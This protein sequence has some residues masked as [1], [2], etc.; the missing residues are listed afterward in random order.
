MIKA[1]SHITTRWWSRILL[2]FLLWFL[3]SNVEYSI[4]TEFFPWLSCIAASL[5]TEYLRLGRSVVGLGL[6]LKKETFWREIFWGAAV[7][8]VGLGAILL[9]AVVLGARFKSAAVPFGIDVFGL[10]FFKMLV[11]A[12]GEEFLF[13]GIMFQAVVE[14]FK[15]PLAVVLST[16]IFIYGHQGNPGATTISSINIALANLLFCAMY[17]STGSLWPS[18]SFH[19]SWNFTQAL[20]GLPV[21]GLNFGRSFLKMDIWR[22]PENMRWLVATN[23]FG[24]ESGF[25]TVLFLI[26]TILIFPRFIKTSAF[27][28]ARVFKRRM[29]EA[30]FTAKI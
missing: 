11:L 10:L 5:L 28:S 2:F 13:R 12:S 27:A 23:E 30:E 16:I 6:A 18:I 19:F 9:I 20:F 8:F 21:S 26:V 15:A 29:L 24:I 4:Y 14:R 7:T 17:L 25:L 3:F 1:V 22:I